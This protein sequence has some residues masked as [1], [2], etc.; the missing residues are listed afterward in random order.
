MGRLT[1]FGRFYEHVQR[2]WIRT[3]EDRLADMSDR[4]MGLIGLTDLDGPE[5][6]D[7]TLPEDEYDREDDGDTYDGDT[8]NP[9]DLSE[10]SKTEQEATIVAVFERLSWDLDD[11]ANNWLPDDIDSQTMLEWADLP[12]SWGFPDQEAG[13]DTSGSPDVSFSVAGDGVFTDGDEWEVDL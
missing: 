7:G 8:L 12:D 11:D 2:D 10:A 3:V 6:S 1:R 9:Y 5:A 13:A 4:T